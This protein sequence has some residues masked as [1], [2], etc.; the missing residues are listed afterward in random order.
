MGSSLGPAKLECLGVLCF[1]KFECSIHNFL[2]WNALGSAVSAPLHDEC[3][4]IS[5]SWTV[6]FPN[7]TNPGL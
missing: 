2:A 1:N 4:L 7:E 6:G 5:R 3:F